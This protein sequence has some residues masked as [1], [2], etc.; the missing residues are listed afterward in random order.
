MM[1]IQLTYTLLFTLLP[2][3]HYIR[4]AFIDGKIDNANGVHICKGVLFINKENKIM[5]ITGQ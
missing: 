5:S 4:S 1:E 3:W 2:L